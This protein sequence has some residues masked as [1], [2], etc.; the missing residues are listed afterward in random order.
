MRS[1][2]WLTALLLCKV[3]LVWMNAAEVWTSDILYKGERLLEV[4]SILKILWD[5][6]EFCFVKGCNPFR[7]KSVVS[8]GVKSLCRFWVLACC[9][10]V[11][12]SGEFRY[13]IRSGIYR[14]VWCCGWWGRF[15]AGKEVLAAFTRQHRSTVTRKC[16]PGASSADRGGQQNSCQRLGMHPQSLM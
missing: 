4:I 16:A 14:V 9:T 13:F 15:S 8:F 1:Q 5:P 6:D 2:N 12:W 10:S 3:Q 11:L 7:R